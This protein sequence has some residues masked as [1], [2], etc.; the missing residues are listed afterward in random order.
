MGNK[1][2]MGYWDCPFCGKTEIRGDVTN[3]PACGRARGEVKFYM[4]GHT[5]GQVREEH[6]WGDVEYLSEEQAK[7]VSRNPDWYCSFCNSLNSDNAET[8]GNCGASRADSEANYFEMLR[9]KEEREQNNAPLQPT[10]EE[11]A[12]RRAQQ[13]SKKP[14]YILLAVVIALVGLFVW[15]NGNKTDAARIASLSWERTITV[16]QHTQVTRSGWSLPA[17]AELIEQKS[18]L[19]HTDQVLDHYENR[20]VRRSRQVISGYETYYTY[21]D[22]GNGNYEEV[23]HQRPVYSTEYYTETV[24]QPVYVPVPRYQTKYYYKVWEWVAVRTEKAGAENREPEWPALNLAE[25]EREGPK[26]EVYRIVVEDP[27]K[28]TSTRYRI[29]QDEWS[30]LQPGQEVYVTAKRTGSNPYLSDSS[31]NKLADLV[32]DP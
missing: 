27:K 10:A 13:K 19:H 4:K 28:G 11:E 31:G 26:T 20:E 23:P 1:I 22:L 6:E 15:M 21:N 3:C 32:R 7:Y 8:C 5:E 17:G 2:V 14:L 9:R 30:A 29:T 18:E 25:D 12:A 16:E 24:R